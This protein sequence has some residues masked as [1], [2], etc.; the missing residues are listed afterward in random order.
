[1]VHWGE[2]GAGGH[3]KSVKSTLLKRA[4]KV[5]QAEID[6]R[7]EQGFQ[8]VSPDD[9][10]VLMIEYAVEG[11]GTEEDLEKRHQLQERMDELLGWTGL[12]H[13]DGGS[14]GSGSMEVCNFVVDFDLAKRVIETD[15]IGSDFADYTR[16]YEETD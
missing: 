3:T 14:I 1:M 9:H 10:A 16:I 11:W 5:I 12:G 2:L 13:C 4:Q 6:K 7:V 15:L 8:T